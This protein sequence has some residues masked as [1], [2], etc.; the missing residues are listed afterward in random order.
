MTRPELLHE[1]RDD[2]W[3]EVT[4][5]CRLHRISLQS[6]VAQRIHAWAAVQHFGMDGGATPRRLVAVRGGR[7]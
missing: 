6:F 4:R 5:Y 1:V 7:R 2:V 3:A